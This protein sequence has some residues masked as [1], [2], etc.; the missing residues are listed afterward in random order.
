MDASNDLTERISDVVDHGAVPM[1]PMSEREELLVH[2]APSSEVGDEAL[3]VAEIAMSVAEDAPMTE[4][5][6]SPPAITL[7][8]LTSI[9]FGW[10]SQALL[11]L[12]LDPSSQ[13]DAAPRL[14]EEATHAAAYGPVLQAP[15]PR[16]YCIFD[17]ELRDVEAHY[18]ASQ[19]S[20]LDTVPEPSR[21]VFLLLDLWGISNH[22]TS[23]LAQHDI[24]AKWAREEHIR[25]SKRI[26]KWHTADKY[27][28]VR[29]MRDVEPSR[30]SQVAEIMARDYQTISWTRE[31]VCAEW[32]KYETL[33]GAYF[34]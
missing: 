12:M 27:A 33:R 28:M 34:E 32:V 5:V 21:S 3:P 31:E 18:C 14:R 17:D 15:E 2:A 26:R 8:P 7:P 25:V 24:S 6:Q 30:F 4:T 11:P 1:R 13:A 9:G 22:T 20:R 19:L 16:K 10:P 23:L 29:A